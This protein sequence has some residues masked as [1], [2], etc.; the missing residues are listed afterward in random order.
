M[1]LV[2]VFITAVEALPKTAPFLDLGL[3]CY[4]F[5]RVFIYLLAC[6]CDRDVEEREGE[7][8]RAVERRGAVHV[9]TK[10]NFM[11]LGSRD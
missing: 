10:D 2:L 3:Y 6:A 1:P 11:E 4:L 7:I 5:L 9:E 8:E